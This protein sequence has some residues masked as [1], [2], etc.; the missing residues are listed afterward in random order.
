MSPALQHRRLVLFVD[1]EP[2]IRLTLP[3]VL[4]HHGFEVTTAATVPEALVAINSSRFDVLLS[5]LNIGQAG[6][7]FLVIT[8]MRDVQPDCVTVILTGYP[9][10]E[11][12]LEA[13][14]HQVDDYLVKPANI[15]GL[16]ASL[17]EKLAA[18][19]LKPV[20]R[21]KMAALLTE[22]LPSI[23]SSLA[24][25]LKASSENVSVHLDESAYLA[26]F[27]RMLKYLARMLETGEELGP[28]PLAL[29]AE[30]G[31]ERRRHGYG[32]SAIIGDFEVLHTEILQVV[33]SRLLTYE[34]SSLVAELRRIEQA[35][36]Q[37]A[38][39]ALAA[40]DRS[41][42]QRISA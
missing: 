14:R 36:Y 23:V 40:Y 21:K 38:R 39:Q 25:A 9:A 6:D 35:L 2:N 29:A 7:G 31:M 33:E 4:K 30:H 32:A 5:D 10:F 41:S 17:R 27:P 1:D 20:A 8:A 15:E 34:T 37:F 24:Q 19:R 26:R 42:E 11:T 13:I 22:N 16:V 18:R 28:E 3:C 12:A